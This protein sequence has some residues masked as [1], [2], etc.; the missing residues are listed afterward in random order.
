MGKRGVVL[1]VLILSVMVSGIAF[2]QAEGSPAFEAYAPDNTVEP[3]EETGLSV[4]FENQGDV[5]TEGDEFEESAVTEARGVTAEL[6]SGGAPVTVRTGTAQ[7]GT[8]QQDST[9]TQSFD[10]VVDGDAS[11]GTYELPVELTYRYTPEVDGDDEADEV[12]TTETATVELVVDEDSQFEIEGTTSDVNVGDGGDATIDVTNTVPS[13]ASEAVVTLDAPD[14]GLDITSQST[15]IYVGDWAAGE[16]QAIDFVAELDDDALA[17]EYTINVTVEYLDE[18]DNER[19]SRELRTA[20]ATGE[21]QA[22]S[23]DGVE[24]ELHVGEDGQVTGQVTNDGPDTAENVVLLLGGGAGNGEALELLEGIGGGD[25]SVGL[26]ENVE[27]RE[28]QYAVGSLGP[29][30]SAEF[31]FPMAV[32]SEAE[33]GPRE[34]EVTTRYRDATGEVRTTGPVDLSVDVAEE[35]ERFAVES[36]DVGTETEDAEAE[37]AEEDATFESGTTGTLSISVTNEYDETLTNVRAQTFTNDPLSIDD[38]EA[39]V[40]ELDP[41][42]TEV[43]QFELEVGDGADPQT[44]PVEIDFQYDEEGERDQLSNT[45]RVPVTVTEPVDDGLP[46]LS[47]LVVVVVALLAILWWFREDARRWYASFDRP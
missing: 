47:V 12:T 26:G 19:T 41:G 38:D 42:E 43:L 35:R 22:F 10:V 39:F 6:A 29:G 9:A 45:Y 18:N 40:P 11:P 36:D 28:T 13:D 23:V 46:W 3:G 8:I 14:A 15:E 5:V 25:P 24:S 2:A 17:Q 1:G 20:L 32:S 31:S 21:G 27:P 4:T 37:A 44:Y 16:T 33:A 30:E 34:V 7:L